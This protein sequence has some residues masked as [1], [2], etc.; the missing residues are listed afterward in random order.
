MSAGPAREGT[1]SGCVITTDT[2]G[3]PGTGHPAAVTTS[4][5]LPSGSHMWVTN[6]GKLA[7]SWNTRSRSTSTPT[8]VGRGPAPCEVAGVGSSSSKSVPGSTSGATPNSGQISPPPPPNYFSRSG[9]KAAAGGHS[10]SS[11]HRHVHTTY[12]HRHRQQRGMTIEHQRCRSQRVLLRES[13]TR[14][15]RRRLI[16]HLDG[17]G[18]AHTTSGDSAA[19]GRFEQA[20]S[21]DPPAIGRIVGSG[22]RAHSCFK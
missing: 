13:M 16:A 17:R 22:S 14:T 3:V 2:P 21:G 6:S 18:E 8:C 1:T 5:P 4:P 12:V 15:G 20:A 19:H 7:T 11:N 9:G 10:R